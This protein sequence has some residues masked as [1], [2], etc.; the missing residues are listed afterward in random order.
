MS[1]SDAAALSEPINVVSSSLVQAQA[2]NDQTASDESGDDRDDGPAA[3]GAE[4]EEEE[5][6]TKRRAVATGDAVATSA[7]AASTTA[8]ASGGANAGEALEAL[9]TAARLPA[10]AQTSSPSRST[11]AAPLIAGTWTHDQTAL[12]AWIANQY[13]LDHNAATVPQEAYVRNF[14]IPDRWSHV[15]LRLFEHSQ[16]VQKIRNC[17]N[18]S[19][20]KKITSA[21]AE[22]IRKDGV[23]IDALD[24]RGWAALG[25]S[26]ELRRPY[27]AMLCYMLLHEDK[28]PKWNSGSSARK[29]PRESSSRSN[30]S[31]SAAAASTK[32]SGSRSAPHKSAAPSRTQLPDERPDDDE[33]LPDESVSPPVVVAGHKRKKIEPLSAE[34]RGKRNAAVVPPLL[35]AAPYQRS[36][37]PA[38]A[39][40]AAPAAASAA[41][42][43]H[44]PRAEM[45]T[46]W[47]HDRSYLISGGMDVRGGFEATVRPEYA[48]A[49]LMTDTLRLVNMRDADRSFLEMQ[50]FAEGTLRRALVWDASMPPHLRGFARK[51][52]ATF[53]KCLEFY[54]SLHSTIAHA[55]FRRLVAA[56][57]DVIAKHVGPD[58]L[59]LA[60]GG[61]AASAAVAPPIAEPAAG[62]V[63]DSAPT[64]MES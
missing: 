33:N 21:D 31:S 3:A 57:E 52:V 13:Y 2:S 27:L 11:V 7:I 55:D 1:S 9:A 6:P 36:T 4:E 30:K 50:T 20:Q 43:H 19:P 15:S 18:E 14:V 61:N 23:K 38:A 32:L 58:P 5:R 17:R 59:V 37:G 44:V 45:M 64:A 60:A 40:Y 26:K 39:T 29:E 53:E 8:A 56:F 42:S 24:F 22:I 10:A 41:S 12:L 28:P 16:I 25:N 34:E 54:F 63:N 62:V 47:P 35:T 51:W 49:H 48:Q 46:S